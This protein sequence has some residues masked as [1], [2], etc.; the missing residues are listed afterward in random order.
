MVLTQS[1]IHVAF[2]EVKMRLIFSNPLSAFVL[3]FSV[4]ANSKEG[5]E[6]PDYRF[7][8]YTHEEH[9]HSHSI[10]QQQLTPLQPVP[11]T[12]TTPRTK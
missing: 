6:I 10:H 12:G 9:L 1:R 5:M 4:E 11:A 2:L 7:Q 8:P 3:L